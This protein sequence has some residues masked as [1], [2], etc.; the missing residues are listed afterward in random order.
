V[1]WRCPQCGN[2]NEGG[3]F[4][5]CQKCGSTP[6][7]SPSA[8]PDEPTPTEPP[9][10]QEARPRQPQ[11]RTSAA[12]GGS[13]G[14]RRSRGRG[15]V[16]A[17]VVVLLVVLGAGGA[18]VALVAQV[19]VEDAIRDLT[20]VDQS[21]LPAASLDDAFAATA[22]TAE[23]LAEVEPGDQPTE[24]AE[25]EP[26]AATGTG[27]AV[28]PRLAVARKRDVRCANRWNGRQNARARRAVVRAAEGQRLFAGVQQA[29]ATTSGLAGGGPALDGVCVVIVGTQPD[30]SAAALRPGDVYAESGPV[31]GRRRPF[32]RLA[33]VSL[34]YQWNAR[35]DQRG[36][37]APRRT[38]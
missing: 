22:T 18:I 12:R 7:R 21:T 34:S 32:V 9:A 19:D 24:P 1:A 10:A 20:A 16:L 17:V 31:S 33:T 25:S 2:R 27:P 23:T 28:A 13:G 5:F 36:R 14:S 4:N 15:G 3:L 30:R 26:P 6:P 11:V 29:T 37:I 8:Q 35:V 38:G